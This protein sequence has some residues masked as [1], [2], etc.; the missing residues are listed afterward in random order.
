M[1]ID[2]TTNPNVVWRSATATGERVDRVIEYLLHRGIVNGKVPDLH[3]VS[4]GVTS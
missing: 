1:K 2:K 3:L 4:A